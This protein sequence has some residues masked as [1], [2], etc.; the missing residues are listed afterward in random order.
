MYHFQARVVRVTAFLTIAIASSACNQ[1][2]AAPPAASSPSA[3]VAAQ[4][5]EQRGRLLVTVG[6]S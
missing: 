5:A 1:P 6:V 4:T 3:P 2:P